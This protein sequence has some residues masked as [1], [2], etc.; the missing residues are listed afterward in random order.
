MLYKQV[1]D[2]S[3]PCK[4][5]YIYETKFLGGGGSSVGVTLVS[6]QTLNIMLAGVW[7]Q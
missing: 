2:T 5:G 1:S 6:V 7:N 4:I 3:L